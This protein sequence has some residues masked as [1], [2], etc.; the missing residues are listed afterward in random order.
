M[1]SVTPPRPPTEPPPN[2]VDLGWIPARDPDGTVVELGIRDVI[3]R[4]H[5]LVGLSGDLPTQ[6]FALTRLLL[7]VLHS[8]LRGPRDLDEWEEL[9][10]AKTLPVDRIDAYLQQHRDRFALFGPTPFMQVAD[11]HTAKNETFELSRLIAD[12]PNGAP[13]FSARRGD[14]SLSLAEAARWLVHAQTYDVSG[15][16][17]GAVGDERVKGGRGY[18]IGVGWAG[19][20]GGVLLEGRNLRET[21]LLNLLPADSDGLS[22]DPETDLPSWERPPSTAAESV[23]GGRTPDGPVDLYT[24]QSRRIRLVA[25]GYRVTRVLLCNGDKLTP[26]NRHVVEPLTGWRRSPAQ[27]RKPDVTGV[28]YMPRKHDPDRSIWRGLQSLLPAH[29]SSKQGAEAADA[30]APAVVEWVGQLSVRKVIPKDY[31][32]HVRAVGIHYGSKESVIDEVVHD[33]LALRALLA[34]RGAVDE[35]YLVTDSVAAAEDA[36]RAVGNLA[37]DLVAAAGGDG[38]GLRS[39]TMEA[40]HADLDPRFRRWL[41]TVEPGADRIERQVDWHRTVGSVVVAAARALLTD[42]PPAAWAVRS[43]RGRP[44]TAAHADA[45]FRRALRKAVPHA[46]EDRSDHRPDSAA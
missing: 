13:M 41:L 45:E 12:V 21:L 25:D 1:L 11:L 38:A 20:L 32:F 2:L 43:V 30:I 9:W 28:V 31:A 10:E 16:K 5:Q 24:W 35:V 44:L 17:S 37:A 34:E 3:A 33:S 8:A 7:A 6:A 14:L 23:P 15:I 36:V 40:A 4:A 46:F 42:L 18:P 29:T 27:E 19:Q 39:R 26:Q 22:R